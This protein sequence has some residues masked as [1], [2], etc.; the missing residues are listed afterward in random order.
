MTGKALYRCILPIALLVLLSGCD[1]TGPGTE[2]IV[3]TARSD[4]G[5]LDVLEFS[6]D[7]G[8][9]QTDRQV[10]LTSGNRINMG[11]FLQ[12]NG[13]VRDDI[14]KAQVEAAMLEVVFPITEVASFLNSASLRLEAD[15]LNP[16]EV[17][18]QD[19]FPSDYDEVA[20]RVLTGRDITTYLRRSDFGAILQINAASLRGGQSYELAVSLTLRLEVESF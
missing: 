4:R 8:S 2:N 16:L 7:A 6:F 12:R 19:V 20:L 18:I 13:F 15:G 3:L 11:T 10:N 5:D 1:V 17:A 9:I 14:V